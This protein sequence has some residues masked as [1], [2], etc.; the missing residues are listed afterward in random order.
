MIHRGYFANYQHNLMRVLMAEMVEQ[1]ITNAVPR[2]LSLV[3]PCVHARPW[4]PPCPSQYS[5]QP[6]S[7]AG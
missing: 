5:S 1:A 3:L 2:R 7:A 6:Q 4:Q